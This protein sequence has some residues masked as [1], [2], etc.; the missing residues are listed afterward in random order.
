MVRVLY[1]LSSFFLVL[2]V[3]SF[4]LF[5]D[6]VNESQGSQLRCKGINTIQVNLGYLC[7]KACA[8]CHIRA[9]PDRVEV[10]GWETM[11]A[12]IEHA[13][14]IKP[15]LVDI[16][17]G[18]PEMN[19]YLDRFV[20]EL[21]K[22]GHLVQVR[23]NLTVLLDDDRKKY[24]QMYRENGVKLVASLP[25]YEA[26]EV[27]SVRGDGTF[28]ESVGVLK[29][30]NIAGYGVEERLQLDLVFNPEDAFL[31][32]N[33]SN[34]EEVFKLRLMEDF[35]VVFNHL[36]TITN[37]T[38]GRFEDRLREN[39]TLENYLGLLKET[40]NPET[41]DGLMCRTQISV[42][43]DGTLYDCDF[44]LANKMPISNK[45]NIKDTSLDLETYGNRVIVT[46]SHCF[47]CTA[48]EGSSCGG[49]LVS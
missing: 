39:G 40:Y 1:N 10:M 19:P 29:D 36:I 12:I 41:L 3:E 34:L 35:G 23:T 43:Y 14:K 4:P 45:P 44:N 28:D 32:P 37:M 47:G 6:V 8:H 15:S 49:A 7:N 30:L 11:R 22:H 13:D 24:I 21:T 46:G 25:C 18:A 48:G 27:D 42:D 16:T 17:G 9:G 38:V 26:A 20:S 5:A 31:P 2:M 33:Q